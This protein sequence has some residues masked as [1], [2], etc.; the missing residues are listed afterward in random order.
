MQTEKRTLSP[1]NHKVKR[2]GTRIF[3]TQSN[4]IFSQGLEIPHHQIAT[5]NWSMLSSGEPYA[6]N[7]GSCN[8]SN[9]YMFVGVHIEGLPKS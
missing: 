2:N 3:Q 5:C 6:I 9:S 1:I 4:I 8:F 7:E